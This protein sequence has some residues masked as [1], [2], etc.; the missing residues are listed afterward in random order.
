MLNRD[1]ALPSTGR[2]MILQVL[3]SVSFSAKARRAHDRI[4]SVSDHQEKDGLEFQ[5]LEIL[6]PSPS[7][8]N[9]QVQ[10]SSLVILSDGIVITTIH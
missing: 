5:D 4:E 1:G 3:G 8:T 6:W 2:V 10:V 9:D 7:T